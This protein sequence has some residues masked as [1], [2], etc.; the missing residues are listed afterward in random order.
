MREWIPKGAS[1]GFTGAGPRVTLGWI[2]EISAAFLRV[3]VKP[4]C[5]G[6]YERGA[7]AELSKAQL[8]LVISWR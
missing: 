2:F 1:P 7:Y 6:T 5:A 4:R 3:A 8:C